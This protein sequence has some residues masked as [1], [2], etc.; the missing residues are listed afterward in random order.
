MTQLTP[1]LYEVE[2]PIDATQWKIDTLKEDEEF[3]EMTILMFDNLEY[4]ELPSSGFKILGEVTK[5][6]SNVLGFTHEEIIS[7]LR[8]KGIDLNKENVKRIILDKL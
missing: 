5:D 1:T 3:E 2:V 8:S 6:E 7:L 4:I